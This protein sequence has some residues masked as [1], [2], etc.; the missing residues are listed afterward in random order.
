MI[1]INS[2]KKFLGMFNDNQEML[3]KND[4]GLKNRKCNHL[5]FFY[6]KTIIK[7]ILSEQFFL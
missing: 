3:E 7:L 5:N 6:D 4:L 1:S 2:K